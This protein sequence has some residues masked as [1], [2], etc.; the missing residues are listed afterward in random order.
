MQL[1]KYVGSK[2][3]LVPT[4]LTHVP[5]KFNTYYESFFGSGALFFELARQGRLDGVACHLSDTSETLIAMWR[6]VRNSP[7]DVIAEYDELRNQP[8][9]EKLYYDT[10]ASLAQRGSD[11][12]IA[13]WY[14]YINR[15]GFNGLMRFNRKGECNTPW[16]RAG[17]VPD[18]SA[19]VQEHH[20]LLRLVDPELAVQSFSSWKYNE[21]N[22]VVYF[23]PPYVPMSATS[24]FVGY[25]GAGFGMPE[26]MQLRDRFVELKTRGIKVMLSNSAAQAVYDLYAG[27]EI[28]ELQRSGQVSCKAGGRGKVNELLIK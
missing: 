26:Q 23:D 1:I 27:H 16:N 12:E 7:T 2:S 6:A 9:T 18:L 15:A 3:A 24:C 11:V 19:A 14:L 20:K 8:Q 5:E 28:I 22:A 4:L 13:A 25:N 17:R 21:P 10:R